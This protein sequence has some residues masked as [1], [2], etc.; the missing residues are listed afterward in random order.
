MKATFT[1][2][3]F[4]ALL[5]FSYGQYPCVHGISTNPANPINIELPSKRNT[6]FNWQDSLYTVQPITTD[7]IRGSKIE[8]PFFKTNNLEALRQSKDM[9]W[10][11]G[12]ELVLRGFG[13]TEQNTYTSDPVPSLYLVLYNR[14]TGI[15]RVLLKLCRGADYSMAQISVKFNELSELKSDLLEFSRGN[16]SALDKAF[17]TPTASAGSVYVNDNTKWFYADF[18]MMFDPCTCMYKSKLE[19]IS[20]LVANSSIAL[21]GGVTGDIYTKDVGGKAQVQKSGSFSWQDFSGAVKGKVTT[22]NSSISTFLS[23]SQ[24]LAQNI[25]NIDTVNKKSALDNL[26]NA[27]KNNNF[28]KSGLAAVPWLSSA[29]SLVDAF[30]GGGNHSPQKVEILPLSVNLTAKLNGTISFA[31][32]YHDII[33][34]NPGSKDAKLDPVIYPYYNEVMGVFN[35]VKTPVIFRGEFVGGTCGPRPDG[36]QIYNK[37]YF[38]FDIDSFYYAL[39]PAA[40]VSI[41]NMQAAII[42]KSKPLYGLN[43]DTTNMANQQLNSSF[44]IFE[45]RDAIS[46]L[47][48]FRTPYFNLKCLDAQILQYVPQ[49]TS[50]ECGAAVGVGSPWKMYW[51]TIYLKLMINLKRNNTNSTT[52]NILMVL[53]YPMKVVL[54]N[55]LYNQP[56]NV[57]CDTLVWPAASAA[58]INSFCSSNAY[59]SVNR[60]TQRIITADPSFLNNASR[61]DKDGITISPNPN[62]GQFIIKIKKAKAKLASISIYNLDGK[63]IYYSGEGN[64]NLEFG[65]TKQITTLLPAGSYFIKAQTNNNALIS[66]F[67]ITK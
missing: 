42:V 58:F 5:Q 43:V 22:V 25:G 47:W 3:C 10:T 54:N 16:I 8:S 21:E 31:S 48:K 29:V 24:T 9:L 53:T 20:K 51:D 49:R 65:Y 7:C 39:N 38:R 66:K 41:Q 56:S 50:S 46:G 27:L 1:L 64:K 11:D 13:L 35:L 4:V 15:L 23:A 18:P 61:L 63:L 45:G 34:T 40:G 12:W 28:L 14:Y 59:N 37:D 6:F 44:P 62:N 32:T 30:I 67:I 55:T 57:T 33:F 36:G 60:Q 2:I 26:A 52:Q 19:I 17:T